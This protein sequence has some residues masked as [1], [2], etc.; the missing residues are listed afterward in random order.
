M[1]LLQT[2]NIRRSYGNLP[3]L[4]GINLSIESGEV[5]SI[6]GA[7]GA[8]KTTLLQILGTLDRPDSGDLQINGQNVFALNDRQLAKFRNEQIGFVFQ[9]NNLLPEFTALEN[10][11]LPGFISGKEEQEVRERAEALLVTLGLQ[12]RLN[13][14]PSQ[15]SGGEQQRTAVARALI[16]KPAIVFADEPSGNLDS[17]NAEELHQLFFRLRQELGQTFI[18]VTHN[19]MLA[20]LADRTVTIR[21]GLLFN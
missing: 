8:G 11:C 1:P 12:E 15:M 13:H 18:I 10:V 5:V 16:N 14:L 17:R 3:V 2:T 20:A 7:S 6:V 19:E 21:D 9:F 4:K